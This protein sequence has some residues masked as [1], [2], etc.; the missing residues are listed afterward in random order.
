MEEDRVRLPRV[1]AP[2]QKRPS[3]FCLGVRTRT[4]ARSKDRR[5]TDDAGGV[6]SPVATVDII[7]PDRRTNEFLRDVVQLVGCLGATE[8]AEQAGVALRG[9]TPERLRNKVESF[10]PRCWTVRPVFTYQRLGEPALR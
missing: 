8:H 4:A 3:L 6:S 5:Q 2:Q 10:V 7:A 1:R 9:D